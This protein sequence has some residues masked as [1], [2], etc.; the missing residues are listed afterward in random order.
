VSRHRLLSYAIALV[1]TPLAIL[2]M[3]A[4][5]TPQ[6]TDFFCFWT[7][8]R[9]VLE[10]RDP[11]SQTVWESATAGVSFDAL[12]R[13]RAGNCAVRYAYPLTTAVA[14]LPLG[15]LPLGVAAAIWELVIFISSGLGLM[16]LA[17]AA[18][19]DRTDGLALVLLVVSTEMF[20]GT[21]LNAQFGGVLLLA[22]GLLATNALGPA[23]ATFGFGLA[24]LKPHVITLVPFARATSLSGRGL[25]VPLIAAC[26]FFLVSLAFQPGWPASWLAELGGHR[27]EMFDAA[28]SLWMLERAI[29]APGLAVLLLVPT[30]ALLCLAWWEARP[31]DPIDGMAVAALA[32]QLVV[33]Y[34]LSY[35][36]LGPVAIAVAVTLRRTVT[37]AR[38]RWM[39]LALIV[40]V[41]L[42][43]WLFFS[44]GKDMIGGRAGELEVLNALVPVGAAAL[45]ALSML[46][47]PRAGPGT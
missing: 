37:P 43:P 6:T 11:Y 7:G 10:G 5:V 13:F 12:G 27:R 35:D 22:L 31:L 47:T 20:Y 42:L 33:P 4:A 17:K 39:L 44:R 38:R 41:V 34:G 18:R 15:A 1:L 23:R 45:L 14:M 26:A 24:M 40:V 29:N 19:L 25:F 30:L 21:V 3:I 28:V 9:L 36:Q 46:R 16:L 32:W 2:A 8:S